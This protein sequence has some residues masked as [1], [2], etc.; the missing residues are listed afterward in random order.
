MITLQAPSSKSV[1]H[2]MVIAA[3]LA[4]GTSELDHILESQDLECTINIL[5]SAGAEIQ[6][7]GSGKY[8]VKGT[9][10]QGSTAEPLSCDAHESGTTC[11]LLTAV[12][13]AGKGR[14]RIHGAPRLHERPI[15]DLTT[16]LQDLGVRINFEQ[17]AGYPPFILE[18]SGLIPAKHPCRIGMEESSQ[19]LSGLLLAAPLAT[20]PMI[21]ELGG[22]KVVSWPYVGLTLQTLEQF[23]VPFKMETRADGGEW[24][25]VDWRKPGA[26]RPGHLRF[27]MQP[28]LYHAGTYTAEG[29]WSGASYFLAAGVAGSEAIRLEGLNA[30]SLQGD[31]A[32]L[33]ILR[34]MGAEVKTEATSVT[35]FPS[36]LRGVDYDMSACPDLVPTVAVLAAYA[37]GTTRIRNVAHLR[38]KESDRLAA[39]AQELSKIGVVCHEHPDGL[40]IEGLGH[41]PLLPD[42]ANNLS[43]SSHNDHRMAMSLALLEL[44]GCR[45]KLDNPACVAKS[46]PDF[47][48]KWEK[49]RK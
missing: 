40:D 28:A 39:P 18:S 49:V 15:G 10:P 31:R 3:A 33:D 20:A 5:R 34:W 38:L 11:R 24:H 27:C 4:S 42:S 36:A 43:F 16:A 26:I 47:W 19:Y 7:T 44:Y 14:F 45:I 29:D 8:I 32:I 48:E 35:V 13:A 21:I 23:G 17:K 37:N 46:F 30:D 41:P 9:L 1:S 6:R 25:Q 2:R 12:L 22:R